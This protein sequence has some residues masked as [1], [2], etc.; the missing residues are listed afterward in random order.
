M[1]CKIMRPLQ[2]V[3][4][5]AGRSLRYRWLFVRMIFLYPIVYQSATG[6]SPR[7]IR[8]ADV[9]LSSPSTTYQYFA[10]GIN[11]VASTMLSLRNLKPVRASAGLLVDYELAWITP[12]SNF[13]TKR[14]WTSSSSSTFT[15]AASVRPCRHSFV[16][17]VL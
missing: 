13:L 1:A 15:E 12:N 2:L 16:H 14:P 8:T 4:L 17:G 11:M 10:I 7:L 9:H 3:N 5:S 6:W